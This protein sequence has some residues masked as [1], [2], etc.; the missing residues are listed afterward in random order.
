MSE[1]EELQRRIMAALDRIDKG[2]EAQPDTGEAADSDALETLRGDLEEE[3]IVNAQKEERIKRL[4]GRIEALETLSQDHA[5]AVSKLD[6]ELQALR[7]ANAQLR[8][9]NAALR[10]AN[11]DGVSEPELINKSMMAELEGLRATHAA[12]RA[13]AAAVLADIEQLIV[14]GEAPDHDSNHPPEDA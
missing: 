3:R 1:I 10:Q 2:L 9:N 13:E 6:E 11:A 8:D 7:Q 12:D 5:D 4:R 14:S